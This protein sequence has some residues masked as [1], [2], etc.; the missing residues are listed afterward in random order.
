MNSKKL[1]IIEFAKEL[2]FVVD[3][4]GKKVYTWESIS[5]QVL[6]KFKLE[7]HFTTIQKWSKRYDWDSLFEKIKMAGIEK[8]KQ[9]LQEKEKQI[10]DEK[11]QIIADIYKSNKQLQKISQQTILARLMGQELKDGNGNPINSDFGNSDLIRVLQHSET[12]LLELQDK[13]KPT[14]DNKV[15]IP[16]IRW[17]KSE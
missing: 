16:I 3:A 6:K 10:I 15:N 4:D 2:Y 17:T 7:I 5:K 14:D 11:S 9:Q 8:G 1:Q 13:K 12:T